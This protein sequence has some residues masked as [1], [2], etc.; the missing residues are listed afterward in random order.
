MKEELYKLFSSLI[1]GKEKTLTE[2]VV[3]NNGFF[4][5]KVPFGHCTLL[6]GGGFFGAASSWV[7]I[8]IQI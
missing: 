4:H 3:L 6:L 7:L 8:A 1:K 5:S 2:S